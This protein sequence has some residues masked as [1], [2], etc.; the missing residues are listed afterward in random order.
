[1]LVM[2]HVQPVYMYIL[3]PQNNSGLVWT[4]IACNM[5]L[6]AWANLMRVYLMFQTCPCIDLF[7]MKQNQERHHCGRRCAWMQ[8]TFQANVSLALRQGYQMVQM[9]QDCLGSVFPGKNWCWLWVEEFH[10]IPG[11]SAD[12]IQHLKI[13]R[14]DRLFM[15][16]W[17]ES[18]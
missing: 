17:Y 16:A 1:M 3:P 14:G 5:L 2:P 13:R 9:H 8:P 6:K 4:G 15:N 7:M 18:R 11:I 10:V 12:T